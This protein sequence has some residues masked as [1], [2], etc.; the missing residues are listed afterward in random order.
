M[1]YSNVDNRLQAEVQ[2]PS[3][4]NLPTTVSQDAAW[5]VKYLQAKV[6]N[7]PA[8][9]DIRN[10]ICVPL[11]STQSR[12]L[13]V[14]EARNKRTGG[15]FTEQDVRIANCLARVAASAVDRARLFFRIEEWRQSVETLISFNATVNQQLEPA[16]MVRELVANV[17]GFLDA[18]GGAAGIV[19][20]TDQ[21]IIA[22]CDSFY[23]DGKW[24][25]YQRQWKPNEGIPGIVLQT[26]FP[27]L[28]NDYQ[29]NTVADAVLKAFDIGSCICVPIKNSQEEVLGFFKLHRRTGEPE[30]S[31]QDAAFLESLGNTAAVAIENA[32]LVKSLEIKNDQIKSLSQNHVRR[33]EEERQRIARELHDQTGQV[34]IGLKL[35][36]QVLGGLLNEEQGAAKQELASLRS[37]LNDATAQLK[38]LAKRLRP[39]T[40]D[41]LGFEATLRQ[42]VAEYRQQVDFAIR[43]D[44][45]C[46]PALTSESETALYRIAQE[47]LTNVAKH[48]RAAA[49][50]ITFSKTSHAQLFCIRDDGTGFDPNETTRGLGLIGIKERVKMLGGEIV[51]QTSP[52]SGTVI[53]VKLPNKPDLQ[54]WV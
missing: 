1:V 53:E 15:L 12:V 36:L 32:R 25:P 39:P 40:L 4:Q 34:L 16:E 20:Q 11:V 30:F 33:L 19:I 13:G 14:I 52:G 28:I 23:F 42:L 27:F 43:L 17:T 6:S 24:Y 44:F 45:Q 8:S 10:S 9:G 38:D 50:E 37:Q 7:E 54:V 48:S 18:D 29:S 26:E 21:G 31:W 35:R 3:T 51:I 22:E 46:P 41:E 5:C 47:S 2:S 49:V